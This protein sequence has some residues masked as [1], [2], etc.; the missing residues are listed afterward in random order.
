MKTT[1]KV[2]LGVTV[3]AAAGAALGM[4]VAPE[5]GKDLRRKI[6][7]GYKGWLAELSSIISLGRDL[8]TNVNTQKGDE[9]EDADNEF[10]LANHSKYLEGKKIAT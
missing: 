3:A 8:V 9:L 2:I 5:K 4:L 1:T 6:A 10:K 7:E